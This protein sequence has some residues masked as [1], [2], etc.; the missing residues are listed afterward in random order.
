M[1]EA[2]ARGI[3]GGTLA[4]GNDCRNGTIKSFAKV[5]RYEAIK[6]EG[7]SSKR[8]WNFRF[9]VQNGHKRSH[10]ETAGGREAAHAEDALVEREARRRIM[11]SK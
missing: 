7:S 11:Q 5:L 1:E 10:P 6:V 9:T 2:I 8:P 4:R 3:T